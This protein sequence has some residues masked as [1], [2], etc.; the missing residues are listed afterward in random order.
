[1]N[2]LLADHLCSPALFLA[3][4]IETGEITL[5]DKKT[6]CALPSL[7]AA[8]WPEYRSPVLVVTTDYPDERIL[9]NLRN[10]VSKNRCNFNQRCHVQYIGYEWGEDT[11]PLL[12][13][14]VANLSSSG[15]DVVILS[16]LLHFDSSDAVPVTAIT[17]LL[18]K[19]ANARVH[20]AAGKYIAPSVCDNF[21]ILV[22]EME[23]TG[24]SVRRPQMTRTCTLSR[25]VL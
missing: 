7:L 24:W 17:S 12:S 2:T 8:A 3:E 22:S 20:V 5:C 4:Q 10:N 13:I 21:L 9:G 19:S 6:G 14:W 16:D 25:K 1:A 18:A 23:L 15:Y 11:E